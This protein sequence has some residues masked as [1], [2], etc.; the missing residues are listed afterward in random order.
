MQMGRSGVFDAYQ[1]GPEDFYTASVQIGAVLLIASIV[2]TPVL[3]LSCT[4]R[5]PQQKIWRRLGFAWKFVSSLNS[6]IKKDVVLRQSRCIELWG[7]FNAF[8]AKHLTTSSPDLTKV[9]VSHV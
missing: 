1:F 6:R 9:H 4:S 7:L 2:S 5:H 3:L 8:F